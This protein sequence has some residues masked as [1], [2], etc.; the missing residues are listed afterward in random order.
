MK[1][2]YLFSIHNYKKYIWCF[3]IAIG[4]LFSSHAYPYNRIVFESDKRDI[5]PETLSESN[6][7]AVSESTENKQQSINITGTIKDKSDEPLAG[8]NIVVKGTLLGVISDSE[9]QYSI[10][11]PDRNAILVFS[12]IG[13]TTQELSVGNNHIVD[14]ILNESSYELDEL[15][16][17]GYGTQ[18][19]GNLT[20]AISTIKNEDILTT[21]HTSIGGRLQGKVSGLQIRQ[22]SG[23]PGSFDATINIRGFG[24]ALYVIDGI[25]STAKEF[26]QLNPDDIE[27]ISVLKDGSAAIYGLNAGNGVILVTTKRGNTE[28]TRFKYSGTVSFS[29]PTEMPKMMNA[30]QWLQMRNDAAV[31][32]GNAPI[33]TK[34]EI[35]NWRIG[36][37]GYKSTDW[38]DETM[39]KSAVSN[40]HTLSAEGGSERVNY[41]ASFGYMS[42]PGLLKSN[43]MKYEQFSGRVNLTAKLTNRLTAGIELYGLYSD[44]EYP[45]WDF[46]SIMRGAVSLQPI[47]APYANNNPEYP[48]YVFDGQAW[49][50]VATSDANLGGYA[51]HRNKTYRSA[52]SLTYDIPF[53]EGL[54]IKGLASYQS[55][56]NTSKSLIKSFNMYTYDETFD[57]YIPFVYGHPTQ[58]HNAWT[59]DNSLLL[60]AQLMY[61]K[62]LAD[63]HNIGVTAV[64]EE[65]NNWSRNSSLMREFQFYTIDQIDFGDT[66]NQK[67]GGNEREEGYRS[68]VGRA[69]Y[70]YMGKYMLEL[71]ARYDGSYRYHP[72]KRWGFFPVVSAGWRISE[73]KFFKDHIPFVYNFKLRGSF[74]QV[75]ENAGN[76]FQY[77][78]GFSLNQ[79]SYEFS[80]GTST[81]GV[82]A[83][84]VTNKNL[85]WYKSNIKDIGFDLGLL[86]G[87]LNIEFDIYQRDR[88]GLLAYRNATLPNTFGASLP[89]ENLN[90][91]RVR[92]LEFSVN[93]NKKVTK[94]LSIS[95][96][97]NFN[98]SRTMTIYAERGPFTNSMDRYRNGTNKRWNDIIWMYEYVGQF[99]SIEDIIYAPIQNG[100]QGNSRELPGDFQYRDVNNDG[101][102][103][104]NDKIPLEWGG[105][106]KIHYGLT[107]GAKWKGFDFNMLWQGSA[108]YSVMFTHVYATYLWNDANMPSYF[109]DRWRLSDPYDP[110]SEWIAGKWPAGRRQPDMGAMYH[111]S[112]VWRKDASYVRLKSLEVGYTFPVSLLNRA[113]I[114]NLRLF[115]NGYNLWTICDPFVKSFDPERSEG[116]NNAGWVYPLSK[117]FNVGL[118]VS[119]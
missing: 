26:Q 67:N 103:D 2:I 75:G 20:S 42:D 8:V 55:G 66:D 30:Y 94:D 43:D 16:V 23:T 62:T 119:F 38:Y 11:I 70:D 118:N 44:T 60:Q 50:S 24:S 115:V 27:N 39:K 78:G 63:K 90:K 76:A 84:G 52:A 117:S 106:P 59:D 25:Q 35:E 36:A 1:K 68:L 45:A 61:K 82:A 65:R 98:Y 109:M 40:Q 111:E 116:N 71:A 34:E 3:F 86:N 93:F 13:Y 64:Y 79:G 31:N 41:Y 83:P 105:F 21:T 10:H 53:V 108:K 7:N 47:H 104:E 74:G 6:L 85:T 9:G 57:N 100:S 80:E 48:A 95:A 73:E 58:L 91:D 28:K 17:V 19:K 99:Q 56:L 102:I 18:K 112:G 97:A 114:Q 51:K 69:T 15:V 37:P 33:Y 14:V 88:K 22:N 107:L 113:G 110:D 77:I 46:Y 32:M 5:Y 72:D 4:S 87:S 49:N 96:N 89:Q 81:S 29:S 101:V 92:G 54:Q 12:Y